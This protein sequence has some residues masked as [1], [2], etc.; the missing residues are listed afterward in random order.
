MPEPLPEES[1]FTLTQDF[2]L[3]NSDL[4]EYY[5]SN[6]IHMIHFDVKKI[7]LSPCNKP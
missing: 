7:F 1:L 2:R 6:S 5:A 4:I 3:E